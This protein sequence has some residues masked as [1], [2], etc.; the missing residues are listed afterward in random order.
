MEVIRGINDAIL[1]NST[2][3]SVE[4]IIYSKQEIC[5]DEY[6]GKKKDDLITDSCVIQ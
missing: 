2:I 4:N 3:P 5:I 6:D 1:A